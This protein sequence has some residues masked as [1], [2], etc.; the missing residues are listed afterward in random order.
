[1]SSAR[2]SGN[3]KSFF[4]LEFLPIH[5]LCLWKLTIM[6]PIQVF[7]G[8]YFSHADFLMT[9][10]PKTETEMSQRHQ[11][12]IILR[13]SSPMTMRCI[14]LLLECKQLTHK[15]TFLLFV[16][17][18]M[19]PLN[20]SLFNTFNIAL[21]SI[22]YVVSICIEQAFLKQTIYIVLLQR[23]TKMSSIPVKLLHQETFHKH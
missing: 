10:I 15:I 3:E 12:F 5:Y 7:N 14:V 13:W 23:K 22:Y 11:L 2:K 17:W 20:M 9:T 19:G 8:H 16:D 4:Y 21:V 1:M 6:F 18:L